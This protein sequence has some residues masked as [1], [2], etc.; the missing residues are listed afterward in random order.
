MVPYTYSPCY[1]NT[2]N[3][4]TSLTTTN[5]MDQQTYDGLDRR[6]KCL[7]LDVADGHDVSLVA[8]VAQLQAKLNKFYKQNPDLAVLDLLTCEFGRAPSQSEGEKSAVPENDKQEAI[9]IRYPEIMSAYQNLIE[10]LNMEMPQILGSQY[11][12]LDLSKI[13]AYKGQL[14]SLA[15]NCHMLVVKNLIVLE[16]FIAMAEE[17]NSFWNGVDKRLNRIGT[18]IRA[19][20]R[21]KELD[22]KY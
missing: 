3:H 19:A 10:L 15:A 13:Q 14:E 7:E 5:F 22:S 2:H 1:R 4:S 6:L 20:E 12:N 18:Q 9:L 21:K 11:E 17:E 16:K 8:Q